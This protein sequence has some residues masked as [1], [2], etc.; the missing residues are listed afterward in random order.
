M[1]DVIGVG[2]IG[3][4]LLAIASLASGSHVTAADGMTAGRWQISPLTIPGGPTFVRL[5]TLTGATDWCYQ[6]TLPNSPS[7][8]EWGCRNLP[9]PSP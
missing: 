4:C 7:F 5:N 2:M 3:A 9:G 8:G 1:K 6:V